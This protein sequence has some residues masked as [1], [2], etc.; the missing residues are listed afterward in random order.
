[1]YIFQFVLDLKMVTHHFNDNIIYK[2]LA[3][4]ILHFRKRIIVYLY[5]LDYQLFLIHKP[6]NQENLRIPLLMEKSRDG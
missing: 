1:M 2:T 6:I 4:L 3:S 5:R